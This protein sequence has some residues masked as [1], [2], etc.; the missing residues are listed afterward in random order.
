MFIDGDETIKYH[1]LEDPKMVDSWWYFYCRLKWFLV[2]NYEEN[3]RG[4]INYVKKVCGRFLLGLKD[5]L[6]INT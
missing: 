3:N 2:A 5:K 6:V 1:G 4:V